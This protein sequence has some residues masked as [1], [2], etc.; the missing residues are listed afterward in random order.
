MIL[1]S[2]E[3]DMDK[4]L[5]D[6][7]HAVVQVPVFMHDIAPTST[8][9]TCTSGSYALPQWFPLHPQGQPHNLAAPLHPTMS[10]EY[11]NGWAAQGESAQLIVPDA[12]L[13]EQVLG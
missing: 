5:V 4:V 1:T 9:A 2:L 10:C 8:P 3:V 6:A 7:A 13:Y 11:D 12:R